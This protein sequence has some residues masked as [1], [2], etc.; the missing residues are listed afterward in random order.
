MQE[1]TEEAAQ[2]AKEK[3]ERSETIESVTE[4]A[5]KVAELA[6]KGF[7]ALQAS[8]A[9]KKAKEEA[10]KAKTRLTFEE[11]A[12]RFRAEDEAKNDMRKKEA[13]EAEG[14]A[15]TRRRALEEEFKAKTPPPEKLTSY[16]LAKE[17]F[18]KIAQERDAEK[19]QKIR[20]NDAVEKSYKAL[21]P[22]G[23]ITFAQATEKHQSKQLEEKAAKF[24]S[25]LST[26]NDVKGAGALD[27][28]TEA[29]RNAMAAVLP[30]GGPPMPGL[31]GFNWSAESQREREKTGLELM[32]E[33]N[34]FYKQGTP[35]RWYNR[36]FETIDKKNNDPRKASL[37]ERAWEKSVLPQDTANIDYNRRLVEDFSK[38]IVDGL[39]NNAAPIAAGVGIAA[40]AA[41]LAGGAVWLWN[42]NK[43]RK[44]EEEAKKAQEWTKEAERVASM[45]KDIATSAQAPPAKRIKRPESYQPNNGLPDYQ[46]RF[47]FTPA[48]VKEAIEEA[49]TPKWKIPATGQ[50]A[51]TNA[52]K[53]RSPRRSRI[54]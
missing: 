44:A 50:R 38:P 6:S 9:E 42:R 48:Q 30:Y 24:W 31:G 22:E 3:A 27:P 28:A 29:E 21:I 12:A 11:N 52:N 18:A 15:E 36:G 43:K 1:E 49:A 39:K 41:G 7:Q 54:S 13:K 19:L 8:R 34:S 23:R 32:N 10:E 14:R 20:Q 51:L 35:S 2:K 40:I 5:K 16:H 37:I 45:A 33:P 47:M 4:G 26:P 53:K 46:P 25:N 17:E